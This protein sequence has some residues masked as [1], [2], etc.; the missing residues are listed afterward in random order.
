MLALASVSGMKPWIS[1]R[2]LAIS[3][4]STGS[5]R[6]RMASYSNRRSGW[7]FPSLSSPITAGSQKPMGRRGCI[8]SCSSSDISVRPRRVRASG[9]MVCLRTSKRRG[10]QTL[11]P[12]RESL[13]SWKLSGTPAG[14]ALELSVMRRLLDQDGPR[15]AAGALARAAR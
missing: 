9:S 15:A 3:A 13:Y 8:C 12:K 10:I 7:M 4:S 11:K 1:P 2:I 6:P 14:L 5:S